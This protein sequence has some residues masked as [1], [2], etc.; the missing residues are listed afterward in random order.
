MSQ[1]IS[2][3]E[4]PLF[5]DAHWRLVVCRVC[6]YGVRPTI[7]QL[8]RHLRESHP[9]F[10]VDQIHHYSTCFDTLELRSVTALHT[11]LATCTQPV[12]PVAYISQENG[13]QCLQCGHLT[14]ARLRPRHKVGSRCR[15][16][17]WQPCTLQKFFPS[18]TEPLFRVDF[19]LGTLSNTP[20]SPD[21]LLRRLSSPSLPPPAPRASFQLRNVA[22][23]TD[24]VSEAVDLLAESIA[25]TCLNE[26][27]L[28]NRQ[29]TEEKT[30]NGRE[31]DDESEK[32]DR[33]EHVDDGQSQGER[34][35]RENLDFSADYTDD[36]SDDEYVPEEEVTE[37]TSEE[38]SSIIS[39]DNSNHSLTVEDW[40]ERACEVLVRAWSSICSCGL[41]PSL[42]F[43]SFSPSS[44]LS[45]LLSLL[46][47]PPS[48]M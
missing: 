9:V 23:H 36:N 21:R 20:N 42:V 44:L 31:E 27:D 25:A 41:F 48:L 29:E 2:S 40:R 38:R 32:N 19:N 24:R 22:S 15:R 14:A 13:A 6:K 8:Q 37:L 43:P 17:D 33:R 3:I 30:D 47:P 18:S 45:S 12:R 4:N 11:F 39:D 7:T 46:S 1:R 26:P 5:Y 34:P 28:D 10:T 16:A 35:R